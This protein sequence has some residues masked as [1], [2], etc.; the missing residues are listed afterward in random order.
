LNIRVEIAHS[1]TKY[2]SQWK[3]AMADVYWF[4]RSSLLDNSREETAEEIAQEF[5]QPNCIYLVAKSEDSNQAFGVLKIKVHKT[6][7]TFGRWEPAVRKEHREIGVGEALMEKAF[8]MLRERHCSKAR[9][10]MKFPYNQPE[11]ASWHVRLYQKC[12]FVQERP[13]G[14]LLIA[15]LSQTTIKVPAIPTLRIIE[16]S[17]FSLEEFAHFTQRAFLS[18][19]Q[20]REVHQSDPYV[21]D[22]EHF[23]NAFGAI[24]AGKMGLSP[25]ECWQIATLNDEIA[26]FVIGFMRA[27]SKY[28]PVHGIIGEL[29]IFPEFRRRGIAKFLIASIVRVF[30]KNGCTYSLVGTP[31]TN[32][33]AIDLYRKM[34]FSPA[35]EQIDFQKVL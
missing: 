23:L 21:S 8:S 9:C 22:R 14:I 28:L 32:E 10:I 24:K 30:K 27:Q 31:K 4:H 11:T 7:G 6:T 3:E 20:D 13:S 19:P 12:G 33:P 18:T 25:P 15:D 35:F 26:G 5:S 2:L 16:G 34:S 29:G 1:A 17:A